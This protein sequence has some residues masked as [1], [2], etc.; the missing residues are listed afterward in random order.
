MSKKLGKYK[1]G[2]YEH[3]KYLQDGGNVQLGDSHTV[4]AQSLSGTGLISSSAGV[5]NTNFTVHSATTGNLTVSTNNGDHNVFV[6]SKMTGSII[7]PQA[8][9]NNVGMVIQV[10]VD[11]G[12]EIT[13]SIG[14]SNSGTTQFTNGSVVLNSADAKMDS[15]SLPDCKQIFLAPTTG[16]SAVDESLVKGGGLTGTNYKFIYQA[17]DTI[18]VEGIGFIDDGTP[19][20]GTQLTSSTGL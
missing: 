6:T 10:F 11:S 2:R 5:L 1:L 14:V 8:T 7:L 15:I 20:L 16:S 13:G 9:A 18:H 4:D 19:A 12:A 17:A 3:Q